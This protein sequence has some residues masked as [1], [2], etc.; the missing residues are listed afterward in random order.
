[1]C[2]DFHYYCLAVLLLIF[3]SRSQKLHRC[4]GLSACPFSLFP[5]AAAASR[6]ISI[7]RSWKRFYFLVIYY[8]VMRYC[9]SPSNQGENTFAFMT[10][11][12]DLSI[13]L[14]ANH[15]IIRFLAATCHAKC[16][17]EVYRAHFWAM[18]TAEWRAAMW[19][20]SKS[21]SM[22]K[23]LRC[24]AMWSKKSWIIVRCCHEVSHNQRK[25]PVYFF[26]THCASICP[27][28]S[29]CNQ[30]CYS[31]WFSLSLCVYFSRLIRALFKLFRKEK[32]KK[33]VAHE[34]AR[35]LAYRIV[36]TKTCIT[37]ELS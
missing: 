37:D 28:A 30:S 18:H 15:K 23:S 26:E 17:K 13:S 12:S 11:C 27:S 24:D 14:A 21:V 33:N 1:M 2:I 29:I 35:T 4:C 34:R 3:F 25:N 32:K 36:A 9:V 6:S 7:W 22:T 10:V 19:E 16:G 31:I 20:P 5:L 8:Y